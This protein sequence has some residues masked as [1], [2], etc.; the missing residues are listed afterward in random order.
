VELEVDETEKKIAAFNAS[1]QKLYQD[2]A[3]QEQDAQK[4]E[5]ERLR[6]MEKAKAAIPQF[7]YTAEASAAS[8]Q[9]KLQEGFIAV[10]FSE[11]PPMGDK[12]IAEYT[13]TVRD[14]KAPAT[15]R[16]MTWKVFEDGRLII[17]VPEPHDKAVVK[18]EISVFDYDQKR[19]EA[20]ILDF[21]FAVYS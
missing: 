10:D 13:V 9:L 20:L 16:A 21:A 5:Q 4:A 11:R 3:A 12:V 8:T 2:R 6:I 14:T 19:L 18:P 1:R 7:S 15:G 17:R